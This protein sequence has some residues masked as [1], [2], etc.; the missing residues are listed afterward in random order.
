[1]TARKATV[2]GGTNTRRARGARRA[3]RPVRRSA[4][5][6]RTRMPWSSDHRLPS[7]LF[8]FVSTG[9]SERKNKQETNKT[10]KLLAIDASLPSPSISILLHPAVVHPHHHFRIDGAEKQPTPDRASVSPQ[11]R[12]P[13]QF[14]E[15]YN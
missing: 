2:T 6:K 7:V 12:F 15:R 4:Q 13:A 1:M 3:R 5:T 9:R 14:S 11:P 8:L 10:R